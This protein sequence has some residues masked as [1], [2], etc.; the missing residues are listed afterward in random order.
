MDST[1]YN[2]FPMF[3][4]MVYI[5]RAIICVYF[6]YS[7]CTWFATWISIYKKKLFSSATKNKKHCPIQLTGLLQQQ[8]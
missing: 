3:I 7:L 1:V 6:L 5:L 8:P 4:Y 2:F